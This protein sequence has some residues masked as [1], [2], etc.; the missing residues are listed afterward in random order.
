MMDSR[1][2]EIVAGWLSGSESTQGVNN[3]AGPLYV[4]GEATEAALTNATDALY[5]RCSSC[6]GSLNSYCC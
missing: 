1:I 4:G 2:D 6:T 3:P 5:S